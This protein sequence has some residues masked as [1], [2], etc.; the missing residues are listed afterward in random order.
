M[1]E[2]EKT[3]IINA[4]NSMDHAQRA[5]YYEQKK[6]NPGLAAVASLIIPGL[7]QIWLGRIGRGLQI[8]LLFW[9][10]VPWLYGIYDA[11]NIAKKYNSDLYHIIY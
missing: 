11:Y 5:M 8:L 2:L 7:G 6:K 3:Q 4:A 9:L 10:F 1:D